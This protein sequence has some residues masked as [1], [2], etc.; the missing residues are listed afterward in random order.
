MGLPTPLAVSTIHFW[1]RDNGVIP[2]S[3]LHPASFFAPVLQ[4]TS[5]ITTGDPVV[6]SNAGA[7]E[8]PVQPPSPGE[9]ADRSISAAPRKALEIRQRVPKGIVYRNE[10]A[11]LFFCYF[12]S[13][14][15]DVPTVPSGCNIISQIKFA[16]S[17]A[18]RPAFTERRAMT[19]LRTG[20]RVQE[21]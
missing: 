14:L 8:S 13:Q 2:V 17:P 6:V 16:I 19:L 20:C 18:R 5:P 11:A 7:P 21:A 9:L 15:E 1:Y 10:S 3:P 12:V 4:L